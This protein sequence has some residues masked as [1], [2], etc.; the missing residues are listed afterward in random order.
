MIPAALLPQVDREAVE[1][2]VANMREIDMREI[3][4]T[5]IS[6]D[7]FVDQVMALSGFAF[8]AGRDVPIAV[9]GAAPLWPG[10]WSAFCFGTADFE[11]CGGTLTKFYMRY[12][13]PTLRQAGAHRIECASIA[14]HETAHQWLRVLG[15]SYEGVMRGYGKGGEDF[16]RFAQVMEA[17]HV[18]R[19]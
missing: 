8:V 5:Q 14:D 19:R 4:A 17:D 12:M 13:V 7:G 18:L 15:F 1:R 6:M 11:K 10:V 2:I 9:I 3:S 16:Y